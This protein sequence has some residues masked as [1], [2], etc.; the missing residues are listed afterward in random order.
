MTDRILKKWIPA[1]MSIFLLSMSGAAL[2]VT[3]DFP[4]VTTSANG[5]PELRAP[6]VLQEY[7]SKIF[8][9]QVAVISEM[10]WKKGSPAI[11]LR[12]DAK[13]DM[14]EWNI[15]SDGK[16][17]TIS[18]GWPRGL[19]YGV[20]EFLEKFGGVRWFTPQEVKIPR[21]TIVM[22][23]DGKSFRRKPAFPLQRNVSEGLPGDLAR[24]DFK[25]FLKLT[26][27]V[28]NWEW[29]TLF[30]S[31]GWGGS[32]NYWKLTKAVPKGMERLLP[33][34]K[35]GRPQRG[36]NGFGPNQVCYSNLEFREFAKKEVGK[37]IAEAEKFAKSKGIP[38]SQF[39]RWFEISQNDTQNY[40]QCA[41]CKALIEKYGAV[42]GAMLAFINDI[43]SA[44]PEYTFQTFAY[45][46]TQ[47]PPKNI[48]AR[49][50]VIVQ[51][52]FL[53][54]SDL[55]RPISHPNN[56]E[57]RKQYD[58]WRNI[59]KY[60]SVWAYHRLYR[61]TEA[62]PW[63]QG[64]FWNIAENIRY[65]HNYGAVKFYLES[66]YAD[67]RG[68]V[69]SARAFNDLHT[70]LECKLA[71]DPFQDDK[72]IIEEFFQYQYGPSVAEMKAYAAYLKKRIDAIPGKVHEKPL[73]ARGILDAE[74]FRTVNDLLAKAEAK[75]GK[76][77]G[78]LT[79]IAMERIPVDY[80][81][82]E[83][84]EQEG[85]SCGLSRNALFDRLEK[86]VKLFFD[87]YHPDTM[88]K[89][90][91]K[92]V[93]ERDKETLDILN[94]MRRPLPVPA[95]F[96]RED[97]IQI[98]VYGTCDRRL[99]VDDPDAA[100]GKA[101]KLGKERIHDKPMSFGI[102]D[103]TIKKIVAR[104]VLPANEIPQDEKTYRLYFV[105]RHV[106]NGFHKEILYGHWTWALKIRDLY[107][108]LWDPIDGQREY[109]IYVSCKLTGPAYV[110]GS[111]KENAVYVDKL[112][113][114]KRGF[115]TEAGKK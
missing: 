93:G 102:Y 24:Q 29:P 43:A 13:L 112:L 114:V 26:Y 33:V 34:D 17:L 95:E 15:E 44:Y 2:E 35:E 106:P 89:V 25:S 14:E 110:K 85:K 47:D 3:A 105:G 56:A 5:T 18:G 103:E 74:F 39:L 7:L 107:R 53:S 90:K 98:P 36:I 76:D 88:R 115:R 111:T 52:A 64:C 94:I 37:W 61:M 63:P 21:K 99:L 96:A 38:K 8:G 97:V 23:P 100:Y 83:M 9:K 1:G 109:D 32:H 50:N 73:K 75:A 87:R 45:Q 20:C 69:L 80:A 108:K 28:P 70:Y 54:Y 59:A 19:F 12:P 67:G 58:G 55:L 79:R 6:A 81:A 49:D 41:G 72:A 66:E 68:L 57:I 78:L 101:V 51:T 46:F 11:I 86:N 16:I 104:R 4:I 40:C 113:A 77:R 71:D 30:Q 60:K 84:W 62:F 22:I 27:V 48:R 92:T 10:Q 65:Y 91:E 82:I 42:S 31:R